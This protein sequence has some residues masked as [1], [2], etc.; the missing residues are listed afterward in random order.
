[1]RGASE[2]LNAE[3]AEELR[4]S[5]EE[6]NELRRSAE[7]RND[8]RR[9]T[10]LVEIVEVILLAM[11]AVAT[12][13]TGYQ[14]ARWDG[15][16][17]LLYQTSSR[18]RNEA[19]AANTTGG[20]QRLLDT[21]TFNTWIAVRQSGDRKLAD[22]YVRRFS[23]EYRVAFDA[24]L[25]TDP[26]NNIRNAPPGPIFMPQYHNSEL[27]RS[28]RLNEAADVAFVRATHAREI[29]DDYIR[30]TLLFATVLFLVAIG[31]R[32]TS[33][34]VRLASTVL[35]GVLMLMAILGVIGLPRL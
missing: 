7:E 22:L 18:L 20:Q 33:D 21:S 14:A 19:N 15:H 34:R 32:F 3:V 5:V 1:V 16:E 17:A 31:Q 11:V 4:R 2:H 28:D 24:W 25:K 8:R 26:F 12:A 35:A 9:R 27:E 23:P 30:Q 29:S 6:R 13:W 10:E